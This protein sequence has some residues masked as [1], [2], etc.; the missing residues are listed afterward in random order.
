[1]THWLPDGTIRQILR[2]GL[3]ITGWVAM[4]RPLE[5]LL[6]DWWPMVRQRRL[7]ARVLRARIA[8]EHG[9]VA[10]DVPSLGRG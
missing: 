5:V 6:Y 9:P 1:M 8:V 7:C 2:E 3:M 10:G 4:R